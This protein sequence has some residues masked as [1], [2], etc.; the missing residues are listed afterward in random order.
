MNDNEAEQNDN[1]SD[2]PQ[3]DNSSADEVNVLIAKLS[4]DDP[5]SR[6]N[7]RQ[8]LEALGK[9]AV[10]ALIQ[11]LDRPDRQLRWE[12]AKTLTQIGDAAAASALVQCL[13]DE[14]SGVRWV[15]GDALIEL[16]REALAPLL[17][18]L[19]QDTTN[20]RDGAYHVVHFLAHRGE[21]YSDCLLPVADALQTLEPEL[22]T[23]IKAE[24]ALQ[25][26]SGIN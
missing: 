25:R 3:A 10:G 4:S 23:P 5:V 8:S 7:A 24:E 26:L 12:A 11:S 13:G 21:E 20:L 1:T 17:K 18:S 2:H 14:D 6:I 9:V 16:G 22:A 19:I 15:A